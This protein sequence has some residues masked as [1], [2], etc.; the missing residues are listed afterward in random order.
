MRGNPYSLLLGA[1]CFS[2]FM[3]VH[4]KK[5]YGKFWSKVPFPDSHGNICCCET[6]PGANPI[7]A[8]QA[9]YNFPGI[10]N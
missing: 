7:Q 2:R 9:V 1:A 10:Y 4:N 5:D 6:H 3:S 8:P